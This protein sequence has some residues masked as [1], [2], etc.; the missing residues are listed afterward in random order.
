MY[1]AAW[2]DPPDTFAFRLC[3][4]IIAHLTGTIVMDGTTAESDV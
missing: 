3:P 2:I 1:S 4:G